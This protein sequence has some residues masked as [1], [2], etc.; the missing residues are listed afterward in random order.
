MLTIGI[1]FHNIIILICVTIIKYKQTSFAQDI[2]SDTKEISCCSVI[3]LSR[4]KVW[5]R[6]N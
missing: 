5:I 3:H 1:L 4:R 6:R 2:M